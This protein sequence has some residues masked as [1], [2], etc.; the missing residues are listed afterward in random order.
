MKL[1][2]SVALVVFLLALI[3][4]NMLLFANSY[5]TNKRELIHDSKILLENINEGLLIDVEDV[6]SDLLYLANKPVDIFN[7][8]KLQEDFLHLA[9]HKK[10]YDQLRFLD[11]QG[12]ERIRINYNQGHPSVVD[13]HELQNKKHRYYFLEAIKLQ[14]NDVYISPLDLNIEH[15]QLELP[16]KPMI[17]FVTPVL[18]L[19]GN[20]VG[21]IILNYLAEEILSRFREMAHGFQGHV[22]LLNED[23][24]YLVGLNREHEW[25]FMFPDKDDQAFSQ[26]DPEAWK[27]IKNEQ[28]GNYEN[29]NRAMSFTTLDLMNFI[30]NADGNIQ[31]KARY[32]KI[33]SLIPHELLW[34]KSITRLQNQLPL[35]AIL[36]LFASLSLWLFF[37]NIQKRH[38]HEGELESL[39]RAIASERE[40]FIEG[41]TV[42]LAFKNAYG[43]PVSFVSQNVETVFGYQSSQFKKGK[44]DLASIIDPDSLE[45]FSNLI[46]LAIRENKPHFEH[47]PFKVVKHDGKRTWV[48][49]SISIV[50]DDEGNVTGFL[51]Y[52]NDVSLMKEAEARA[53]KAGEFVQTV[54]NSIA[55]PILVIDASSYK[56][57]LSNQAA[58]ET[59]PQK[60]RTAEMTCYQMTH[61]RGTPCDSIDETCPVKVVLATKKVS[62][63]VHK[64]YA[65]NGSSLYVELVATPILDDNGNV[66]QVI[67]AHRD[68]SHHMELEQ[69]LKQLASIDK[70]TQAYNRTKFDDELQKQ[71][72][73]AKR[74]G[75]S[76]GIVMFDIDHFKQ[77][78]DIY[79]H[80]IGDK[81]LIEIVQLVKQNIRSN[82][83]LARW[84]GE[85]FMILIPQ[86]NEVSL[87]VMMENLRHR[88]EEH[89]FSG[90]GTVT[91]SFGATLIC[92]EDTGES[93]TKRVD[94]ALYQSKTDGRNCTTIILST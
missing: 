7:T 3:S 46:T 24:Y 55:D 74:Y 54:V 84:G 79:G 26:F 78:N 29:G 14:H 47:P 50:K 40:L 69:E 67:E 59:Y 19:T 37:T 71:V 42:V 36:L 25:G 12:T 63:V 86:T 77:V 38:K 83:F 18:D 90:V 58:N 53:Q 22:L 81:V 17:R 16:I 94:T 20:K 87:R 88:V 45:S 13:P 11:L 32:W 44:L 31:C 27:V 92:E 39:H 64:H 75:I 48:Q 10:R 57:I 56:I 15:N 68:I 73:N 41:P 65:K 23:G 28:F 49:D 8:N 91:A 34:Q 89:P 76:L 85:E 5:S 35:N 9:K 33:V 93:L 30:S 52:F 72:T 82:D 2:F 51:G 43:W 62:R 4:V 70:L 61:S 60:G 6:K 1:N 80:D 21:V 66:I